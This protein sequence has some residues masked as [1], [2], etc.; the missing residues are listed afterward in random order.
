MA[1]RHRAPNLDIRDAVTGVSPA[2]GDA[3]SA[4]GGRR[5][6]AQRVET[7]VFHFIRSSA[8]RACAC[9]PSP[10]ASTLAMRPI[11]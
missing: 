10:W 1:Q 8:A 3:P 5:N 9:K 11:C 4:K 6:I 7:G 2:G